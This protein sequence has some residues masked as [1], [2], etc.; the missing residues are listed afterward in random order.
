MTDPRYAIYYVPRADSDL[1][2]FGAAV[3]GYDCYS[4][5][6]APHPDFARGDWAEL[7][8]EPRRYG[9]HATLKAPFRLI[10]GAGEDDLAAELLRF[11]GE[12]R[13]VPTIALEVQAIGGF[14]ALAPGERSDGLQLLAA[15]CVRQF[16]RFRAPLTPEDLQRRRQAILTQRQDDALQRW[17]YPYVFDD[18]QFHMTLTGSL[19]AARQAELMQI[20]RDGFARCC[21]G[22][23]VAVDHVALVR[24]DTSSERFRVVAQAAIGPGGKAV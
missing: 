7:T 21:G 10:A 14:V 24:Q 3:L 13:P 12:P 9:F 2:R 5:A 6:A 15:Q 11:A 22:H 20:L 19:A 16:D 17:G 1:Y 8:R 18:F 23:P 4:G